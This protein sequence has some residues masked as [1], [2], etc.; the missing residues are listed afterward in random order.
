MVPG[1][2]ERIETLPGESYEAYWIM[3]RGAGA[4]ALLRLCGLPNNGGVFPFDKVQECAKIIKE[5][6]DGMEPI[7]EYEES[8]LMYSAFYKIL[9]IHLRNAGIPLNSPLQI[10]RK[11][12][13]YMDENY[14]TEISLE[15]FAK[16]N[17][18]SRNYLYTLFKRE[19]SV[20]PKEYLMTRRIE[21]AKLILSDQTVHLSV[22]EVAYVVGFNDPLYFSKVFRKIVGIPPSKYSPR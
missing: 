15:N 9:S 4:K 12:K 16:K 7:N 6:L 10:T 22:S 20:S 21:K 3:F 13:S 17:G 1:E 8:S 14:H 5:T 2:R 11:L 18:I 19:Y